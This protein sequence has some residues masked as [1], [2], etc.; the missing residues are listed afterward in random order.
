M[1]FHEWTDENGEVL[2]VKRIGK[3]RKTYGGFEWP[4]GIGTAVE[5]PDWNPK[6]KCG[7]GLH[8]WPWGFGLGEGSDYDIIGDIWLVLGAKPEDVVGELDDGAKCKARRVVIRMEASFGDVMRKVRSGFDACV[9]AWCGKNK[10]SGYSSTAASSG[11]SSKAASSGDFSTAASSGDSSKAASSGDFS[12][13]A[14]SGNFSTA[15]AIGLNTCAAMA[16]NSGKIRVGERGA[17]AIAYYDDSMGWNFCVGKV[18]IDGIEANTWYE[19]KDGK[20]A[21]CD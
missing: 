19:V 10:S 12:K 20:L 18:G 7:G 1:N 9:K 2:I 11:N 16:G 13:A 14:S 3:D 17:F 21:K 15:E 6:A 4:T 8:G 5:C